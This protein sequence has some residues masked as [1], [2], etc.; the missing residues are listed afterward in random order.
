MI[1]MSLFFCL[2]LLQL[3]PDCFANK[4]DSVYLLSYTTSKNDN[5]NGLHFAWSQNRAEW[6]SVGNEFSFLRSDYGR[7]GSQK[8]M[9][10]PYLVLGKNGEWECVWQLNEQ[11]NAF[12]HASSD[13]LVYW[14]RQSYPV[15]NKGANCLQPIIKYDATANNYSV[16][17]KTDDGKCYSV[18][19]ADFKSYS[20][21]IEVP[22]SEYK[23]SSI[24]V[25][26]D[27]VTVTGQLHKVAWAVVDKLTKTYEVEAFKRIENNETTAQDTQRFAGLKTIDVKFSLLPSKAKP[28]S[29]LLMG[30]FF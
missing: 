7:W 2:L 24:T 23:D 10:A 20:S 26:I 17:Y 8:K 27:G 11:D 12:A 14:G 29:E 1:K 3:T 30:I 19:T 16:T 22:Q 9:F 4:P 5:K 15:L 13:D 25:T 6:T 28:I 18:T 21:V